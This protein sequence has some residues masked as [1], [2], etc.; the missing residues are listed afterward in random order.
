LIADLI[1]SEF[2]ADFGLSNAGGLRADALFEEGPIKMN[3]MARVVPITE[4][5][6][7]GSL[8]GANLKE[9]MEQ[10]LSNCM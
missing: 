4:K 8:T 3:F 1:R 7:A 2:S 6:V 10:G 5:V 9:I